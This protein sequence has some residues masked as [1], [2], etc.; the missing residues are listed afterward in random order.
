MD[1]PDGAGGGIG[2]DRAAVRDN[3]FRQIAETEAERRVMFVDGEIENGKAF[4]AQGFPTAPGEPGLAVGSEDAAEQDAEFAFGA[5]R[6][7]PAG[8]GR[9]DGL[10][11]NGIESALFP[12]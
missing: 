3:G 4:A 6:R 11:V 2:K 8:L 1:A 7:A 9:V 5:E 10:A 12:A